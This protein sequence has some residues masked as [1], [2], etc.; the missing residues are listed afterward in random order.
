MIDCVHTTRKNEAKSNGR[1]DRKQ[2]HAALVQA[3]RE[4]QKERE[5]VCRLL[6]K[7]HIHTCHNAHGGQ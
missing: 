3:K 1:E 4:S 7:T 5:S 2:H 6:E